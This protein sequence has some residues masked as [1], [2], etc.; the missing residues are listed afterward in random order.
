MTGYESKKAMTQDKLA[1]PA[2]KPV[3]WAVVGDGKFGKYELGQV[4]VDYAST[5]TYWE[6]RGYELVP[7]YT[8]LPQRPWV[9]LTNDDIWALHDGYL[10]P[11]E[12]ARAVEAK[13]KKRN[14]QE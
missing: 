14:A 7:V 11:I 12:F 3:S 10:N 13:L 1:Q 8:T 6:N 4:F 5:H 9:G 2:Q